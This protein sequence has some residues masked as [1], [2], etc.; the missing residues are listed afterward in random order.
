MAWLIFIVL[1]LFYVLGLIVFH[2]TGPVHVLPF[3]AVAVLLLD[4]ILMRRY[5]PTI[6][7]RSGQAAAE[8]NPRNHT[9]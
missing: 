8:T 1:L 7:D 4:R 9:K 3:A 6:A 2:A 5:K